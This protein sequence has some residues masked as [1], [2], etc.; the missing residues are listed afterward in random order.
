MMT[1]MLGLRCCC[2]CCAAAG[3]L[4]TIAVTNN[5]SRPSQMFLLAVIAGLLPSLRCE[6]ANAGGRARPTRAS[7]LQDYSLISV[8]ERQL[9]QGPIKQRKTKAG[10]PSKLKIGLSTYKEHNAP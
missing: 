5:A 8:R 2:C 4:I 7:H 6:H 9:P 3:M 1:R 10:L